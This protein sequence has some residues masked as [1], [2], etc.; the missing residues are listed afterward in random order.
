MASR[1]TEEVLYVYADDTLTVRVTITDEIMAD[2]GMN[3]SRVALTPDEQVDYVAYALHVDD[4]E[5]QAIAIAKHRDLELLTDD[6]AGIRLAASEGVRVVTTLDI[7][8][9]WSNDRSP[10]EIAAACYRL[11]T[12]A[13]YGVPRRHPLAQWYAG[14]LSHYV[15]DLDDGY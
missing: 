11:R 10:E 13:R 6:E 1:Y 8:V 7:A 12:R 14:H 4:G 2:A 3:L 15:R 9:A 5:A